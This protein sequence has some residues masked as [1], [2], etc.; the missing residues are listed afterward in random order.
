MAGRNVL[1]GLMIA[2]WACAAS[3]P[4]SQ[5]LVTPRVQDVDLRKLPP[6]PV[7]APGSPVREVPDL[8]RTDIPGQPVV[9]LGA[10]TLRVVDRSVVVLATDGRRI[11]GPLAFGSLWPPAAEPCG[12]DVE[13]PP[14]ISVDREADRW[15]IWRSFQPVA[16]GAVPFCIAVSRTSDPVAG[17][18]WLYDFSLPPNKYDA[19][20]LDI[21]KEAYR[22]AGKAA[23]RAVQIAFDRQAMLS[24]KP[25]SFS[26]ATR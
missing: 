20:Q 5:G 15:L 25:S 3:T 2:V 16:G 26:V 22:L 13:W 11:A 6:S 17:G 18:W 4:G 21:S 7:W 12:V 24:G 10:H 1:G 19:Q 23:E 9:T 14:T 8:K